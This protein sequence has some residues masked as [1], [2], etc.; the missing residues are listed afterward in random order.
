M[1]DRAYRVAAAWTALLVGLGADAGLAHI[2]RWVAALLL[3]AGLIACTP[4][5]VVTKPEV[6]RVPVEVRVEVD[7][8]LTEPTL[9]YEPDPACWEPNPAAAGGQRRVFCNGQLRS[10]LDDY[11]GAVG[12]CNADKAAVRSVGR[13]R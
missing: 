13:S 8:A 2:L 12:L 5:R 6:V 4:S 9:V 11:R 10:M 3:F 7:P 1:S